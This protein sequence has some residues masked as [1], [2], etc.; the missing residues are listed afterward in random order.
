MVSQRKK[1]KKKGYVSMECI[2]FIY[3]PPMRILNCELS[4]SMKWY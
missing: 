3:F 2:P 1:K 4:K